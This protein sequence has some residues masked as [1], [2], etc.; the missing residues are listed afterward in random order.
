[1]GAVIEG[2]NRGS[3]CCSKAG[4]AVLD[5]PIQLILIAL[6]LICLWEDSS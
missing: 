4:T 5:T 2:K 1:M 3:M 6:R